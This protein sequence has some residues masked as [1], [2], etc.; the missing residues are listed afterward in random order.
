MNPGQKI[1][2]VGVMVGE[3]MVSDR[4]LLACERS[5]TMDMILSKFKERTERLS[6][7]PG[8]SDVPEMYIGAFWVVNGRVP[9]YTTEYL[10]NNG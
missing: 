2:H 1:M 9:S 8:F 10:K 6:K 7:L 4:G 3:R 5:W